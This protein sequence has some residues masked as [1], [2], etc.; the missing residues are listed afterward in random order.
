MVIS[1]DTLTGSHVLCTQVDQLADMISTVFMVHSGSNLEN[2]S[3]LNTS[4]IVTAAEMAMMNFFSQA[5]MPSVSLH[6][7][8]RICASLGASAICC[9]KPCNSCLLSMPPMQT[10]FS[11]ASIMLCRAGPLGARSA[12]MYACALLSA[13]ECTAENCVSAA[14]SSFACSLVW[15]CACASM[16][17]LVK[18]PIVNV[19]IA[20]HWTVTPAIKV[21]MHFGVGLCLIWCR[22][23]A[24][25]VLTCGLP[26]ADQGIH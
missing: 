17:C 18:V 25:C 4:L 22:S 7:P 2:F 13:D 21:C 15:R 1:C 20:Q 12:L 26:A 3:H 11:Q 23:N 14:S 10:L 9:I 6:C 16:P 24:V 5:R 19:C 8:Q